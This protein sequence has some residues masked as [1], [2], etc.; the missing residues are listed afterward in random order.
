MSYHVIDCY[1]YYLAGDVDWA[2]FLDLVTSYFARSC[3][4]MTTW[5]FY[6]FRNSLN[7]HSLMKAYVFVGD[8]LI[9][10]SSLLAAFYLV[11]SWLGYAIYALVGKIQ[12]HV[13]DL[14]LISRN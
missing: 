10:A 1:E 11:V 13:F 6:R 4:W 14:C 12:K 2:F 9:V 7:C 3:Q 5:T 8:H